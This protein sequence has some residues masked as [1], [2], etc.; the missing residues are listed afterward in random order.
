MAWAIPDVS[1]SRIRVASRSPVPAA[2]NSSAAVP[3]HCRRTPLPDAYSSRQPRR[4]HGHS[5]PVGIVHEMPD[6]SGHAA[7]AVPQATVEQEPGGDPGAHVEQCE[8]VDVRS[9]LS[10]PLQTAERRGLDV[11]LDGGRCAAGSGRDGGRELEGVAVEA[12]VDGVG[13]GA[14]VDDA[15]HAEPDADDLGVGRQR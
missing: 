15:G 9:V 4:P 5:G 14:V 11:V 8:V 1:S 10:K 6:L 12:Q 2:S 7:R 3:A 13:H